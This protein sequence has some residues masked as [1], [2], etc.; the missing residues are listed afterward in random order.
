M[1]RK[2][3]GETTAVCLCCHSA[4]LILRSLETLL[5]QFS[6]CQNLS[7]MWYH[8][9]DWPL[10]KAHDHSRVFCKCEIPAN[11]KLWTCSFAFLT[12]YNQT[13]QTSFR[14]STLYSH[15]QARTQ[16]LAPLQKDSLLSSTLRQAEQRLS[17]VLKH[18]KKIQKQRKAFEIT[19][20]I[21]HINIPHCAC[22][23]TLCVCVRLKR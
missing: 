23:E 8:Y 10:V 21:F 4:V 3:A 9:N 7:W 15:Q 14:S 19:Q 1:R 12:V 16:I 18:N 11:H 13:K 5:R 2:G 17:D 22:L 6:P 20:T